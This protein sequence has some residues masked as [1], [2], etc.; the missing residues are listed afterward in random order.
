MVFAY[1]IRNVSAEYLSAKI[2]L[3]GFAERFAPLSYNILKD[4][5][6]EAVVLANAIESLLVDFRAKCINEARFRAELRELAALD[7][8]NVFIENVSFLAPV[9]QYSEEVAFRAG[10]ASSGT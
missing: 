6:A 7:N 2:D 8:P 1:Q 9:N 5:R 10:A 4:G 3:K